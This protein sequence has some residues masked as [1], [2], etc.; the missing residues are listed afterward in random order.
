MSA[1]LTDEEKKARA[2]ARKAAKYQLALETS[3]CDISKGPFGMHIVFKGA[4][5]HFP[6]TSNNKVAF[7]PKGARFPIITHSS[8]HKKQLKLISSIFDAELANDDSELMTFG[9]EPTHILI[10]LPDNKKSDSHNYSKP[11][12]DWLQLHGIIDNDKDA[13]AFCIRK[14]DY[15]SLFH[16]SEWNSLLIGVYRREAVSSAYLSALEYIL[17]HGEP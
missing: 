4:A 2:K 13:E 11:V 12:C 3:S 15:P 14:S 6:S 5:A 7:M 1:R 16:K 17:M 8:E 10:A 9:S